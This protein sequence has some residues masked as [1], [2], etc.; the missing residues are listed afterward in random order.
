M[1]ESTIDSN[2]GDRIIRM[3]SPITVLI[4]DP[5][6]ARQRVYVRLLQPEKGIRVVKMVS[7]A[8]EL[9]KATVEYKP[10]ILLLDL[11]MLKGKEMALIIAVRQ[12]S[13]R[14]RIIL[15]THRTSQSRILNALS[16]GAQGYLE[17]KAITT[18]LSK[19]VRCVDAGEAWV[20]RKM[21]ARIIS[22]L[23][24]LTARE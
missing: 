1:Y 4:A 14:T 6:R 21:V 9:I 18:F 23:A 5:D 8:L 11:N 3:M 19:A 16:Y 22:L 12:K 24:R 13:P 15:I 2:D 17:E 7:G 10:R 20:P